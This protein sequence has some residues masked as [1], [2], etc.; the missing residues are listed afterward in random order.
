[1]GGTETFLL[2]LGF[3]VHVELP[4]GVT[5]IWVGEHGGGDFRLELV[6]TIRIVTPYKGLWGG[7]EIRQKIYMDFSPG[8]PFNNL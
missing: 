7:K 8:A 4:P 5:N 1:M 2:L 6:S 3:C